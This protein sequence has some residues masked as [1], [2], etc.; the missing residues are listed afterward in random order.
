MRTQVLPEW[1]KHWARD[2]VPQTKEKTDLKGRFFLLAAELGF[3]P[4]HT[5]SESAVLPL[6]NSAILLMR[7]FVQRLTIL[8]Q[9]NWFVKGFFIFC[10]KIY[11]KMRVVLFTFILKCDILSHIK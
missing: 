8:A 4:R 2:V 11:E 5:E 1:A 3:E 6:H 7:F 9:K 10:F